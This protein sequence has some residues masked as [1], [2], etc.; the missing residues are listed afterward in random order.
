MVEVLK[1]EEEMAALDEFI[2]GV[3]PYPPAPPEPPLMAS[4]AK[5]TP[6]TP[7]IPPPEQIPVDKTIPPM[8]SQ[9][10]SPNS[11]KETSV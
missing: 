4:D 10:K 1:K 2:Q 11:F 7:P 5:S 9:S 8:Q 3:T 6:L